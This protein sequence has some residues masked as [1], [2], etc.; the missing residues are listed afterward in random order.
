M[1]LRN[2]SHSREECNLKQKCVGE[3]TET[4]RSDGRG[5]KGADCVLTTVA[6]LSRILQAVGFHRVCC[7]WRLEDD[8]RLVFVLYVCFYPVVCHSSRP[9][10]LSRGGY[11]FPEVTRRHTWRA[12]LTNTSLYISR[13]RA[14]LRARIVSFSSNRE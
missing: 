14:R 7:V 3:E 1:A 13:S 4:L 5:L 6:S 8:Y 12:G 10:P 11:S 2:Y 9:L